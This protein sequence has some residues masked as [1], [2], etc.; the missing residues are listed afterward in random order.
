MCGESGWK[1]RT[2]LRSCSGMNP[3]ADSELSAKTAQGHHLQM[4]PTPVATTPTAVQSK[5]CWGALLRS[6]SQQGTRHNCHHEMTKG[7]WLLLSIL[8]TGKWITEISQKQMSVLQEEAE[9][10]LPR[11]SGLYDLNQHYVQWQASQTQERQEED[12]HRNR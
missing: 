5:S 9:L 1:E 8:K 3:A 10:E 7:G 2:E 12:T 4:L 11:V 6:C